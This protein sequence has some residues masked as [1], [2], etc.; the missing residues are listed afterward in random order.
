[1]LVMTGPDLLSQDIRLSLWTDP[2]L[3]WFSSDTRES[4]NSGIRPGFN[5]G[6]GIDRYFRHNYAFSTGIFLT[7]CGGNMT[8]SDTVRLSLKNSRAEVLP[9]DK[10]IYRFKYLTIPVGIKLKTDQIGYIS[11]Y[12]NVGLDARFAISRKVNI[13]ALDIE[14]ESITDELAMIN[15]GYH[16]HAGA[17]Y[18]LGGSTALAF[19]LGY[20]SSFFDVTRESST[21]PDDRVTHNLLLVKLGII[22]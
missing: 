17:E 16:L 19:G 14:G 21:Q 12:S 5:A 3:S 22:F 4:S 20:E 2:A 9:Q 10:V 15:I 7:N 8:Y 18:S 6:I 13:P 11:F 1:M